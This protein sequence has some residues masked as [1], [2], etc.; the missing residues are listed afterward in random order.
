MT[1]IQILPVRN[2]HEKHVFLTF[3]WRIY[4]D[5]P[6]WVPPLLSE[7]AKNTDSERGL[8]F[9]GDLAEFF[10]AWKNGKPADTIC[11]A[12]DFNNTR[13][14]GHAECMFGFFECINDYAVA[15]GAS[16]GRADLQ[17]LSVLSEGNPTVDRE[18]WTANMVNC[19]PSTVK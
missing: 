1:K 4:K 3:P 19:P 10:L 15:A 13:N 17:T 9:R 11:V 2:A 7:R 18:R 12:E 6:L 8:F 5:D 14:L 16:H